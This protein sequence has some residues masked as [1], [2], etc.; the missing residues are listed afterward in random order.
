MIKVFFDTEDASAHDKF[1]AWRAKHQDGVLLTLNTQTRGNLHGTRCPHFGSGPPYFSSSAFWGSLTTKKKV[2]ASQ[3]ELLS[4]AK[5]KGVS[6]KRCEQCERAGF[7]TTKQTVSAPSRTFD[8]V[9][10]PI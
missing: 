9:M 7:L 10:N 6:V 1:Q 3:A 5:E 4:W 8:I 2:C